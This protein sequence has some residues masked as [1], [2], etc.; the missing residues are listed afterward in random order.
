MIRIIVLS[1]LLIAGR[2]HA[3]ACDFPPS[4]FRDHS[5]D[6]KYTGLYRNEAWGYKVV[7]PKDMAGYDGAEQ[8]SHHG[9]GMAFGE[10]P[11]S[12]IL[13]NGEANSLEYNS[14]VDASFKHLSFLRDDGKEIESVRIKPS[15]LGTLPA[16]EVVVTY[17][18]PGSKERY[19]MAAVLALGPGKSPVYEVI[20]Y[21]RASRYRRDRPLLDQLL[22]S[23]KYTGY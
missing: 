16:A 7:I 2:S 17:S 18:C 13:V 21:C 4:G 9:F 5:R 20:L 22:K 12:Y 1:A 14:P 10:P 19:T 15:R 11:E 6:A 8:P 3:I 23:W